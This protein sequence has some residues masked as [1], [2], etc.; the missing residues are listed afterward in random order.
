MLEPTRQMLIININGTTNKGTKQMT[1]LTAYAII[2]TV[3]AIHFVY[4][5]IK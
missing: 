3:G 5:A 2:A 1:A 4:K